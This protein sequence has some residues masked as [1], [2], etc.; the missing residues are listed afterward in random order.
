MMKCPRNYQLLLRLFL[1]VYVV[2][3]FIAGIQFLVNRVSYMTPRVRHMLGIYQPNPQNGTFLKRGPFRVL[4]QAII[5]KLY[6]SN[7]EMFLEKG[8]RQML[9]F[10]MKAVSVN[11]TISGSKRTSFSRFHLNISEDEYYKPRQYVVNRHQY[12]FLRN[13]SHICEHTAHSVI[14]V[15]FSTPT[16]QKLRQA[17]RNTWAGAISNGNWMG[18]S[19]GSRAAKVV[20]LFGKCVSHSLEQILDYEERRYN[21]IIQ[22]DVLETYKNMTRKSLAALLWVFTFCKS[23]SYYLKTDDDVFVHMTRLLAFVK[24]LPKESTIYGRWNTRMRV[25]RQKSK[26]HVS[27]EEYPFRQYPSY[28]SGGGYVM[29]V[30]LARVLFNQSHYFP[31]IPIEDVFITGVL[32]RS[33]G[34]RIGKMPCKIERRTRNHSARC[35]MAKNTKLTL[36]HACDP[37]TMVLVWDELAKN[38][39]NCPQNIFL[40]KQGQLIKDL[41]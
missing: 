40:Y 4:P 31:H 39:S 3:T 16:H 30:S 8:I 38:G 22:V 27:F 23:S 14:I 26:W 37:N 13:G 9:N 5:M 35:D 6:S 10:T 29:P 21:D 41:N 17:I 19:L 33:L 20:F 1:C 12:T 11:T 34:F 2:G 18:S 24:S 7:R 28:T 25:V 32:R 36:I 15:I